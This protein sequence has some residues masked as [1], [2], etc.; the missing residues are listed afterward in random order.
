[1]VRIAT[2]EPAIAI[3]AELGFSALELTANTLQLAELF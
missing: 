1:M 2:G 3:F